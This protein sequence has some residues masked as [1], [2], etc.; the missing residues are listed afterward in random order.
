MKTIETKDQKFTDDVL[1][2]HMRGLSGYNELGEEVPD[3]RPVALPVGFTRPRSLQETMQHLLRNEEV[4]RALDAHGMDT[5]EEAD[6]FAVEDDVDDITRGSPYEQDFDPN[7]INARNQEIKAGFVE[8]IPLEKKQR[9]VY[10]TSEVRRR[11][12]MAKQGPQEKPGKAKK[13]GPNGDDEE[14]TDD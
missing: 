12:Q 7:G 11:A 8:E 6:D 13:K 9:A 14:E 1:A 5:F 3:P 4:R 2:N 10:L